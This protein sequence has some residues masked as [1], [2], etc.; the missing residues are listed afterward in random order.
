MNS[1]KNKIMAFVKKEIVLSIAIIATIITMFFI[2]VD[3][4]YMG[5]FDYKTLVSLFCMLAVVAGL[6]NT[7]VFELISKKLIGLFHTRRAVIYVIDYL[8]ASYIYSFAFHRK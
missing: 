4:E 7:N 1:I 5:Y 3:K 8:F 2:P 6:K